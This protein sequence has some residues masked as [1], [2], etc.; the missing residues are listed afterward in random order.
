MEIDALDNSRNFAVTEKNR[1]WRHNHIFLPNAQTGT[2]EYISVVIKDNGEITHYG[3]ILHLGWYN[4]RCKRNGK[5][6]ASWRV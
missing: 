3:R 1:Q 2:N 5:P 6:Y 4:R